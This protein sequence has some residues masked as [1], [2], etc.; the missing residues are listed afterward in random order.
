MALQRA[1]PIEL[2]Q[3]L[4][5]PVGLYVRSWEQRQVDAMVANAF[6]YHAIQIGLP[7]W[8][9][10]QAN[11]IPYK[12]WA[13][14][15]SAPFGSRA[16]RLICE[17]EQLPFDSQSIDLMVMPHTLEWCQDPH[18]VLR[19]VER[20]LMPEGRVVITGFNPYSLWGIRES[21]PGL[22]LRLPVPV[23]SQV[24]PARIKD[25]FKLLSFELDRG[26]FGCYVPLCVNQSW[27]QRWHF[28]EHAGDR[29]WPAAGAVYAIAAVKRSTGMHLVGPAWRGAKRRRNRRAAVAPAANQVKEPHG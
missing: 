28:M 11:R 15:P 2:A 5:T 17:P 22:A 8:D 10:L 23:P 16:G 25:W 14:S 19:E 21:L 12:V 1:M 3:W 13:H 6:G 26:R 24:S 7:H 4:E 27:L 20:A 9:L 18:L 29:W